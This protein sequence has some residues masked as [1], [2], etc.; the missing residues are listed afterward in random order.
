MNPLFIVETVTDSSLVSKPMV[1]EFRIPSENMISLQMVDTYLRRHRLI[2]E[3]I[4][5][6]YVCAGKLLTEH[7]DIAS[8][9]HP[10]VSYVIP[11]H[12]TLQSSM[13]IPQ[14]ISPR[15][16]LT[17]I[18]SNANTSSE[19]LSR[20]NNLL[21]QVNQL[22]PRVSSLPALDIS[23][24][25]MDVRIHDYSPINES[26]GD[27][28]GDDDGVGDDGDE[29]DTD[30]EDE[31]DVVDTDTQVPP[32]VPVVPPTIPPLNLSHINAF[33]QQIRNHVPQT[34]VTLYHEQI[35]QMREFGF[36]NMELVLT[37]LNIA[38]GD[39][40]EAVSIYISMSE[41]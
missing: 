31:D 4:H 35:T 7:S 14:P 20:I 41:T 10:I 5:V 28:T 36:T 6:V 40:N 8:L 30:V 37:S 1:E 23:P 3:D 19:L 18:A 2:D 38:Q 11:R 17:N 27:G 12:V 13:P 26:D 16:L 34:P 24:A 39:V 25:S 22:V 33:I 32:S 21:L 29:T 9:R 15:R